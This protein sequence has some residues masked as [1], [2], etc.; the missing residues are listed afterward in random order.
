MF[1]I[2]EALIGL[3]VMPS[4]GSSVR[5]LI[6]FKNQP[7]TLLRFSFEN[8]FIP[9][10]KEHFHINIP[11]FL[12]SAPVCSDSVWAYQYACV[13]S[14]SSALISQWWCLI[15]ICY[16]LIWSVDTVQTDLF[17]ENTRPHVFGNCLPS[18]QLKNSLL[19]DRLLCNYQHM[20]KTFASF[21]PK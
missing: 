3:I 20:T 15:N 1:Y 16:K 18:Y 6:G 7:K 11:Y 9:K 10:T 4:G 19:L 13:I 5:W 12:N 14:N 8:D 17:V 2:S 21:S